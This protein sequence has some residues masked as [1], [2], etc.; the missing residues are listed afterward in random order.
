MAR[1]IRI[2]DG[3]F[4]RLQ[5]LETVAGGAPQTTVAPRVMILQAG[6]GLEILV[7]GEALRLTRDSLLFLNPGA[8]SQTM[9]A[10]GGHAQLFVFEASTDWLCSSFPAVFDAG[11][12]PFASGSESI[13]Q[14]IRQLAD[15]LAIEAL[16]DQFLSHDRLEFNLQELM[17]SIVE[18]YLARRQSGARSWRGSPL[19]DN[20]IRKAL[21][22]LRAHPNKEVNMN[23]LAS[24]SHSA[25]GMMRG[26]VSNGISR[27]APCSA[28]CASP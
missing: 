9:L 1:P 16:N 2:F 24:W 4:G 23:A 11:D 27:S 8:A 5:L 12:R 26:M 15:T 21:A 19:A 17:L 18:N 25:F 14:R 22:L 10:A 13:T 7:D 3:S 28:P 20:R 6:A